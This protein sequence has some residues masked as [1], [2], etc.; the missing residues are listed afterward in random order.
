[1]LSEYKTQLVHPDGDGGV[2]IETKQDCS[3]IVE[4]NKKEFNSFDERARWGND[5]FSNKVAS[6][7]LTAIDDLQRKGIMRGFAVV[8]Q[9]KF[10][11]WLSSN[12]K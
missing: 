4:Q 2:V 7:P 12:K 1:M 10:N 6:I 11:E 5:I 8:D 3:D 9:K